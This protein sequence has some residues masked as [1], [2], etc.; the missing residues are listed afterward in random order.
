MPA[1]DVIALAQNLARR[2]RA[3]LRW[4]TGVA[5]SGAFA[6]TALL[7][8]TAR[9][10]WWPEMPWLAAVLAWALLW[11]AGLGW[12]WRRARADAR[13]LLGGADR[14]VGGEEQLGTAYEL[15]IENPRHP[16]LPLLL[17]RC[18]GLLR[19]VDPASLLPF[20]LDRPGVAALIFVVAACG[21]YLLPP[22][23][24]Q[25]TRAAPPQGESLVAEEGGRL[26]RFG[27]R[28][29]ELGARE[30][31]ATVEELAQEAQVVGKAIQEKPVSA[32]DAVQR[33]QGL[34][35]LADELS[36]R[37]SGEGRDPFQGE[38]K[39]GLEQDEAG[40]NQSAS[41]TGAVA[42]YAAAG[43]KGSEQQEAPGGNFAGQPGDQGGP[44]MTEVDDPFAEQSQDVSAMPEGT[45]ERQVLERAKLQFQQ[46]ARNLAKAAAAQDNTATAHRG[47]NSDMGDATIQEQNAPG[48]EKGDPSDAT[49][50]T[51]GSESAP[52]DQFGD[53]PSQSRGERRPEGAKIEEHE[54]E[55]ARVQGADAGPDMEQ[56]WV[57]Q[58]PV[59]NAREIRPDGTVP[60]FQRSAVNAQGGSAIPRSH[61]AVVRSYFMHLDRLTSSPGR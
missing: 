14:Q 25:I 1:P 22:T 11:A 28:M 60:T 58:L 9:H 24:L 57:R 20:E 6:G 51:A 33:V 59:L 15:E 32:R 56:K 7:A 52:S 39:V 44:L 2:Q 16:F 43:L 37:A 17:K 5:W 55:D 21:L 36:N 4:R 29:E 13:R 41:S 12:L 53:S 3:L 27:E 54:F 34:I 45:L 35:Q 48:Q 26:K 23:W 30:Q 47:Q 38:T 8:A 61:R 40:P 18:D 42:G 49:H 10:A 46:S 31:M 19:R 50:L